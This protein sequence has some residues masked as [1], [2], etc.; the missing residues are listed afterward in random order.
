MS[1]LTDSSLSICGWRSTAAITV[2]CSCH[3]SCCPWC[4]TCQTISSSFNKTAH[5]H[6]GHVKNVRFLEESTPVFIPPDLW[7][8]NSTDHNPVDRKTWSD[9]QQWVHQ[10]QLHSI[11][12]L[13]KRLLDVWHDVMDQSVVN[14]AIDEWCKRLWACV[15]ATVVNLTIALSVE[16]SDEICFVSSNVTFVICRKVEL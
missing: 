14:N 12:K 15:W 4:A 6:T 16:Q 8:Q 11:D 13:K 9:I 2:T 5:L 3:S 1:D 10:S 7:S